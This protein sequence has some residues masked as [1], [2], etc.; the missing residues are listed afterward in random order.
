MRDRLYRV[1]LAIIYIG[2]AGAFVAGFAIGFIMGYTGSDLTDLL[3]ATTMILGGA[4]LAGLILLAIALGTKWPYIVVAGAFLNGIANVLSSQSLSVYGYGIMT[5]GYLGTAYHLWRH[6]GDI[7]A[8]IAA[9][10]MAA[11]V[12]GY[13]ILLLF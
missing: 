10:L 6:V 12:I 2:L 3:S 5:I 11:N 7:Y 13:I 4:T 9:I 8:K 1:A